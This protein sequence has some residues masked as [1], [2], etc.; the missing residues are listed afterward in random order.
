MRMTIAMRSGTVQCSNA[1]SSFTTIATP[2]FLVVPPAPNATPPAGYEYLTFSLSGSNGT[3][4][5]GFLRVVIEN[6]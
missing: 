6:P 4:D 3:P 1:L 2:V 5:K